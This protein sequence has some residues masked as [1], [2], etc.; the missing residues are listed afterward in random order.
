MM[1]RVDW[2]A[3]DLEPLI[4]ELRRACGAAE[5]ERMIFAF[6]RA[7]GVARVDPELLSHLFAAT[8]CLLAR[9]E[10]VSPRSVLETHFRRA[11]S[12][13]DWQRSYLPLFE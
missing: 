6:E 1:R 8:A 10:G 12:D 2:D 13:D 9:T 3:F 11:V 5:A 7:I 4:G